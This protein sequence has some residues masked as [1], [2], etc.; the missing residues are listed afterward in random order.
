MKRR[1]LIIAVPLS[2]CCI[3]GALP[4]V[5]ADLQRAVECG[6]PQTGVSIVSWHVRE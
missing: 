2:S 3:R 6:G 5:A 4:S 1:L